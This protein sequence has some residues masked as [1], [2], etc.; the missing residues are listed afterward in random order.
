MS[1]DLLLEAS[2]KLSDL[3]SAC[4]TGTQGGGSLLELAKVS[5]RDSLNSNMTGFRVVELVH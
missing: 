2:G 5:G 1:D 4:I 3:E